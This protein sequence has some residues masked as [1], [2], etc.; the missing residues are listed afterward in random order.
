VTWTVFAYD[1]RLTPGVVAVTLLAGLLVG[2]AGALA[3]AVRASRVRIIDALRK[4]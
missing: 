1:L 3:P 4:V 2:L